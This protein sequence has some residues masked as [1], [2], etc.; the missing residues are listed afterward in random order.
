[1]RAHDPM[2]NRTYGV[3]LSKRQIID[4]AVKEM[5]D[6]KIVK[7]SQ[8]LWPFPLVVVKKGMGQIE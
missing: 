5:L 3:P 6:A 4:E 8:S 7:R 1:M 2:K